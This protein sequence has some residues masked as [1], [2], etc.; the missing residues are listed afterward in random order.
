MRRLSEEYSHGWQAACERIAANLR[1][2]APSYD[3]VDAVVGELL[4][5]LA[6]EISHTPVSAP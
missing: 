2:D 1:N 3:K 5:D 4:R 6:D